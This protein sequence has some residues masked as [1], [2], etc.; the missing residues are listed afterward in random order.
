M[1]GMMSPC[2][3]QSASLSIPTRT[4]FDMIEEYPAGFLSTNQGLSTTSYLEFY[5][6]SLEF[7]CV[8]IIP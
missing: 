8:L 4:P 2:E 1:S 6:S 7:A 3:I 5:V